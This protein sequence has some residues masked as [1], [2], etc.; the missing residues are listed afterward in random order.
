VMQDGDYHASF[1]KCKCKCKCGAVKHRSLGLPA[2]EALAS[3]ACLC[4]VDRFRDHEA[5]SFFIKPPSE[6]RASLNSYVA[7]PVTC[8]TTMEEVFELELGYENENE[9][10]RRAQVTR[11][12]FLAN[13]LI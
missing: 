10:R 12:S 7:Q 6:S 8:S 1:G 11:F 9:L 2:G 3:Q 4:Q 13:H 5:S